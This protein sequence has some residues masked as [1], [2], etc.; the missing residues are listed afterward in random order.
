MSMAHD[1]PKLVFPGLAGFYAWASDFAYLVVRAHLRRLYSPNRMVTLQYAGKRL[2]DDVAPSVLAFLTMFVA[3]IAV[4]TICFTFTGLDLVTAY[5]AS[6]TAIANV[7]P[8]L[9][10]IIGPA[11]NFQPL[12]DT[13]KWLLALAMIA[14]R[15]EVMSLLIA[16]DPEFWRY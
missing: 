9:G 16:L 13:V 8:G 5:S 10:E 7:G 3:T 12:P 11:G 15:L 4:F 1:E 6:I 14:G 2:P